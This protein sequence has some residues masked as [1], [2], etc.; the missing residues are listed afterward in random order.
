M[1]EEW[2]N[3]MIERLR[4]R[5]KKERGKRKTARAHKREREKKREAFPPASPHDENSVAS[6]R[7]R[8]REE[9]FSSS[10]P[11]Y[12][13]GGR[14]IRKKKGRRKREKEEKERRVRIPVVRQREVE[15]KRR[16]IEK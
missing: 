8:G 9:D 10:F 2:K 1:G 11:L 16:G 5:E 15:R 13:R 4:G 6:E 12:R 14:K 3:R 7:A